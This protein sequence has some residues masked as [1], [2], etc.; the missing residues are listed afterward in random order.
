[1][2]GCEFYVG[3]DPRRFDKVAAKATFRKVKTAQEVGCESVR[4]RYVLLRVLSEVNGSPWASIA[5]LGVIGE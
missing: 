4:G 5:E 1:M 2:K 3:S